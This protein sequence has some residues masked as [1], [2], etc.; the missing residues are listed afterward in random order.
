MFQL[1]FPILQVIQ[2]ELKYRLT[3]LLMFKFQLFL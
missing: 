1:F 2:S 3:Q